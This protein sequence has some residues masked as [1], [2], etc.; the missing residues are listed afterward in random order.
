MFLLVF[1]ADLIFHSLPFPH[2]TL[3]PSFSL[4]TKLW[5]LQ[6][7]LFDELFSVLWVCL[8]S[9]MPSLTL[10]KLM[11]YFTTHYTARWVVW[12][13]FIHFRRV[14]MRYFYYCDTFHSLNIHQLVKLHHHQPFVA[15]KWNVFLL[16]KLFFSQ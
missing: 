6:L 2:V 8:L 7:H 5:W 12:S 14:G 9:S 1:A 3:Q 15:I 11:D 4:K 10:A 13:S 16:W